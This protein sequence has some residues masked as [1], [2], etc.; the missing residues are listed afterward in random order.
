MQTQHVKCN[1]KSQN[2]LCDFLT[3]IL[4][5]SEASCT[6]S[7]MGAFWLQGKILSLLDCKNEV[8]LGWLVQSLRLASRWHSCPINIRDRTLIGT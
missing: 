5:S 7:K 2:L 3:E 6:P 8:A 4:T 1:D